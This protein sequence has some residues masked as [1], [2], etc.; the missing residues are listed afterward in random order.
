MRQARPLRCPATPHPSSGRI[1]ARRTATGARTFH[2]AAMPCELSR[3]LWN[4][5]RS[6]RMC[7][8]AKICQERLA[9]IRPGIWLA[10]YRYARQLPGLARRWPTLVF[11]TQAEL[12]EG[13]GPRSRVDASALCPSTLLGNQRIHT[14]CRRQ[15]WFWGVARGLYRC[16]VLPV[17][18]AAFSAGQSLEHDMGI[19]RCCL[20]NIVCTEALP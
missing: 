16:G 3:H 18:T 9:S 1:S 15:P 7:D 12:A 17:G 4:G 6:G 14:L 10:R 2:S 19:V 11:E 8:G 5:I 13:N 20:L